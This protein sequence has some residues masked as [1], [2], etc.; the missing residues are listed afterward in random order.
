MTPGTTIDHRGT[1]FTEDLL[2]QLLGALRDTTIGKVRTGSA[3]FDM[4]E[5]RGEARFSEAQFDGDVSFNEARFNGHTWFEDARFNGQAIFDHSMF[6]D[7]AYFQGAQFS[8]YAGFVWAEFSGHSM[9]YGTRF[10]GF[11]DFQGVQFDGDAYFGGAE[12]DT[13][14]RFGPVASAGGVELSEAVFGAPVTLEIAAR[15]VICE[16][17]RW[18]FTA[19]LRLRYAAVDLTGAVLSAPVAVIAYPIPLRSS[20]HESSLTGPAAVRVLSVQGVDAA[21]L[22]L[23]NTDVSDCL[24]SGAFHLD[25]IRLEGHTTFASPP[26]GWRRHGVWPACWSR[27]RTLAEEHQW[28]AFNARQPALDDG[29]TPA[30]GQWRPGPYHAYPDLIPGPMDVAA[31]YRQLRKAFEDSKNEPGAADFYYGECEMRRHDC[32]GTPKSE[33][34]LLWGYWLLSGYGLHAIRAL[35][36]LLAAMALTVLLLMGFGLPTH[37][38]DPSTTGTLHGSKISL[39]TKTPDP[40]LNGDWGDRMTWA[41]AE[42]ATRVAVNSVVFRSSGQNLTTA[43]TCIEMASRLLEPTL[44]AL[45]VLALRGRIKR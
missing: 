29:D 5:F 22:V 31:L 42:N 18:D 6:R 25:Q 32:T 45:A 23:T 27:R 20:D 13:A 24:F 38:P 40:A 15:H 44:L 43:G 11:I 21:H 2:G 35:G 41:R 26:T 33:R 28:R 8:D 7:N 30:T 36:W 3:R 9:F 34:R 17:T 1:P 4:A 19:T 14:S 16:R 37:A 12:F 39:T 10:R